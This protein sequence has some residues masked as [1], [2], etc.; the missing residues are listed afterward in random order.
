MLIGGVVIMSLMLVGVSER[1]REI[2]L[3]R[4]VGASRVDILVQFLIEAL[5][6]SCLGG[7]IGILVGLGGTEIVTRLQHLPPVLVWDPFALAVALSVALG[8]MF[9]SFPAW[10]AARVDPI[11]AL[12]S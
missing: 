3:R 7:G 4:S 12:R 2:G 10:K 11:G 1:Q 6:I 9:G 5:A 8:L